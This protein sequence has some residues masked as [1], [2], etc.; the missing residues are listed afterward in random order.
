METYLLWTDGR[1]DVNACAW[2]RTGRWALDRNCA[3]AVTERC[4]AKEGP[5]SVGQDGTKRQAPTD[6]GIKEPTMAG[7]SN[8]S[9]GARPSGSHSAPV[10]PDVAAAPRCHASSGRRGAGRAGRESPRQDDVEA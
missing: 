5:F 6:A 9:D 1:V 10:G 3:R 8:S 7:S 4:T 2:N